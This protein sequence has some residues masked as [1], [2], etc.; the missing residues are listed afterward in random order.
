MGVGIEMGVEVLP[1]IDILNLEL[2]LYNCVP[3]FT[4]EIG[5]ELRNFY[6]DYLTH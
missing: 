6:F 3:S 5:F 2:I 1:Q 4:C